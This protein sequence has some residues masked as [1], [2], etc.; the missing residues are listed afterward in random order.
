MSLSGSGSSTGIVGVGATAT[1]LWAIQRSGTLYRAKTGGLQALFDFARTAVDLFAAEDV[2]VVMQERALA[3]CRPLQVDC[4]AQM[5]WTY[6]D[7]LTPNNDFAEGLCGTSATQVY[8]VT[9]NGSNV[10]GLY[11]WNGTTWSVLD[12]NL[13]IVYPTGCWVDGTSVFVAGRDGVVRY[14][15]GAATFER[16]SSTLT[17]YYAGATIGGQQW[18]VGESRRIGRRQADGT[19]TLVSGPMAN[20]GILKAVGAPTANEGWAFGSAWNDSSGLA[21]NGSQW[22]TMTSPLLGFGAQSIV[23][24]VFVRSANE[25]YITGSNSNG[26]VVLRGTR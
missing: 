7:L 11:Q 1:E 25:V 21:W 15:A 5:N 20:T 10:G 23:S 9:S 12:R 24:R 8:A 14:Q 16:M 18:V 17:G 13:P 26:P 3:S 4:A 6:F 19:W 22:L 2:V